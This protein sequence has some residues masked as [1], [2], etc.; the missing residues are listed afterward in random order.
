MDA[1]SAENCGF[2]DKGM[3]FPP[4]APLQLHTSQ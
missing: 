1:D 2:W 3:A 4:A